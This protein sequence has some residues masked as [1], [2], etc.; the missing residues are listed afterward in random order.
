MKLIDADSIY[1]WYLDAFKGRIKPNEIRFSMNDIRDNLENIP[2]IDAVPVIR[3]E[4]CKWGREISGN[5]ECNADMNNPSEYHGY[6]WFC[7]LGER[8]EE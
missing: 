2:P 3:C 4:D 5:I 7:P 1:K 6:K 8:K